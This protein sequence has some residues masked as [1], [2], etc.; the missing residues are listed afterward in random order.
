MVNR[1]NGGAAEQLNE[2]QLYTHCT[3]T[4]IWKILQFTANTP[5]TC[6]TGTIGRRGRAEKTV[7]VE[8]WWGARQWLSAI[9]KVK[10]TCYR[11]SVGRGIALLFHDR[12]TRRGWVVSS[13]TRPHFTPGKD[14]VPI[15][16]EAGWA[17]GPVWMVGKSRSHWDLIPYCPARSQLLYRL[18]NP[19]HWV[20]L[21]RVW[22]HQVSVQFKWK[23]PI[24]VQVKVEHLTSARH[25]VAVIPEYVLLVTD[26][27]WSCW[28]LEPTCICSSHWK[29]GKRHVLLCTK[30]TGQ[31]TKPCQTWTENTAECVTVY[32]RV[33]LLMP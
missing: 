8:Q 6:F 17:P 4:H 19:A 29:V 16:Q 27:P 21:Y 31:C 13:T 11:P 33:L 18:S 15:V 14:P 28:L 12:G 20:Q 30:E 7:E 5:I 23:V 10:L 24:T 2:K 1:M 32:P 9:I 22:F 3:F 26:C 25:F